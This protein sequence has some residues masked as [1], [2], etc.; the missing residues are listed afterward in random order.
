MERRRFL[1]SMGTLGTLAFFGT[2]ASAAL[3]LFE[4]P[5]FLKATAKF[6]HVVR[7]SL[8]K[9]MSYAE[10]TQKSRRWIDVEL[11]GEVNRKF[12]DSR[13]MYEDAPLVTSA[14]IEWTYYFR[15]QRAY[16]LWLQT[17][18]EKNVLRESAIH[19]G[20]VYTYEQVRRA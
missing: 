5:T 15:D 9:P 7:C 12:T 13:L 20:Y 16:D 1:Q 19:S 14:Q 11:I 3:S 2:K 6:K 10:F 18:T 4:A 8:P 17:V